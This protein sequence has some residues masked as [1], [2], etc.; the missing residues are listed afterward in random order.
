MIQGWTM[1]TKE[2]FKPYALLKRERV[3]IP[4]LGGDVVVRELSAGEA[5]ELSKSSDPT[6]GPLTMLVKCLLTE[7]GKQMFAPGDESLIGESLPMHVVNNLL[8]VA[9]RLSGMDGAEK[10]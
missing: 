5:L 10:N 8:S 3:A 9:T 2:S 7:D 6:K 4:E 1:I